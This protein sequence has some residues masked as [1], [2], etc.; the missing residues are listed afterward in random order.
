[1]NPR[2]AHVESWIFDLDNSLYPASTDLFALI[3]V[4]MGAISSAARLR[5]G[6]GAAGA[7]G[8]FPEHGTT[9]AG[10]MASTASIRT[11]SSTSST[12]SISPG[13][14]PI[15]LWSRRSIACR[16]Q[17]RLHQCRRDLC[18][19]VLDRLGLANAF[20][21]MHD[22]HA[23][24]YVPKPDPPPM[25]RSAR[26]RHRPHARLFVD[27]MARNLAPAKALGMT[28]VWIDN[29]SEQ[30]GHDADPAFDRFRRTD[31]GLWLGEIL[32]EKCMTARSRRRS[33]R[34]GKSATDRPGADGEVRDA[35]ERRSA[36]ST[37]RGAGRGEGAGRL[38]VNQWLKKAV[39]LSFR[40]NPMEPIPG[41]P[42]AR[43]G[44]TR[45]RP[46]SPAGTRPL[47]AAGFR[48][49]PGAIVR[50]GAFIAKARC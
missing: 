50:R 6:R 19:R 47:R 18:P 8:P 44:G 9:L 29:G 48:A 20:D 42:A 46:S 5:R 3:D 4:R 37:R 2:L 15:R 35:V 13:S 32:G 17:V 23:M 39:L 36:C 30:G 28:T 11:I 14:P 26:A 10:L 34:P 22:I 45:C 33:T 1:M 25:P 40:L 49:V 21:G 41:G 38:D 27:D 7:E 12:T 43:C 24:D 31:I 16:A